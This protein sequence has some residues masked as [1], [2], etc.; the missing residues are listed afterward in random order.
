[1]STPASWSREARV[2]AAESG[3]PT[4]RRISRGRLFRKYLVLILTLVTIAL[5]VSGGISIYFTYQENKDALATLQHEK[6]LAAASRIEQYIGQI[7]QQ[8]AYAALPQLDAGDVELRRIEFLKLLRQAPEVTDI[9]QIDPGGHEQIA[10]SRLGMDNVNS[11]KDRSGEPAFQNAKRGKAWFGPVYFRKETEPYMTIA[12]RSGNDKGPVTVAEV[13]LKFIW[14]VVSRIKIGEK[15]KAYVVDGNGFLIADPDIG[16]VLR[17]TN[18]SNLAHV[19]AALSQGGP[20]EQAMVSKDLADIPVLTAVAP[21]ETLHWDVFVEQPVAEVYEKLN[22]SIVRTGLLLL[23]G[24]AISAVGAYG[25]ARGMVRPIRTLEEGAERI[26]SGNLDQRIEVHTGD[27]L[28]SLAD[29]FN[30]MTAQLRESYAGLE[31]KVEERTEELQSSLEQ[32][33]AI[34]EILRVISSSPTDVQPVLDAVAERAANLCGAPFARVVLI[35][36]DELRPAAD[37]AVESER[38]PQPP[39]KIPFKRSVLTGRA[40]LDLKT[41]HHADI[42]PLLETEYPDSRESLLALGARAVLVV[43]LMREGGAYGGIILFRREPELFSPA[44]VA[45]VETFARQA[46]IAIDNVRLFNETKESLDQQTAISEVLRVISSSP[47]DV[48]P[49]LNAVAERALKLC[50]AAQSTIVLVDGDAL[51]CAAAFGDTRTLEEGELMPLTR[52]SVAGRAVVDGVPFQIED[53]AQASEE[54]LPVGREL[55]RRV[56]HHT[57]LAVPLMR[58]DHAIGAIQLWRMETRAFTEKQVAL[59]KTFADQAAIA[60]ENARLFAEVQARTRELQESLEYQTATSEVLN[61]ISRSPSNIEPVLDA[62]AETAQRLCQSEHVFI[63]RLKD[64]LYH[65]AVAKNATPEQMAFLRANPFAADRG[66]V[67]GR[68]ALER[69][70]I[71]IADVLADPE[72]TKNVSGHRGFRTTLGVPLLREGAVIGVIV[73]TRSMVQPFAQKQIDLLTTFAD[74]AV[75]AIENVRLFNETKES[76]DQQTAI[77]EVLRVISTSPGDVKPMLNAVAE[78]ALSLCDAAESGI[79]F[80]EGNTLR[81]AAG[82]GSMPIPNEN[83]CWPLTRALVIGRAVVD[84]QTIHHADIVPLL[85]TEYPDARPNHEKYGFRAILTVPLMREDRAI[86]G[87][88]LWRREP[89]A[90]T[91][92]QIALVKTFADQAAIA[93]ENVRL[94]NATKEAL[95]QQTAVAE[96]LRVISSSPTDVLPVLDAIAERAARLCDASAASMYLIEGD[97]LHH[98]ASKGPSPDPV[99]HIDTLPIN[100]DSISGRAL[101]ERR[102]IEVSDMLAEGAEYPLSYDIAQQSGHRTVLVV[103]LYREG[104]PFGTVLLRRKDVRPFSERETA[105]LRTFGDQ[106][107]IA[108]ENVRLFNE[109]KEALEQ[110]RASG[111]VLAA[112]SSSIADATPV[113]DKILE[114]CERLFSGKMVGINLVGDDGLVRLGAYHGPGRKELEKIMDT[115]TG[116]GIAIRER[117]TVHFPDIERDAGASENTKRACKAIG[118]RSVVFAP[119]LWEGNGIGTIFVGRDFVG[120]FSE[121]DLAL[122]K[123][124]AD[125]AVIAI[126]NA[127]LFNET[128][129]ALE[130]QRASG[131][132]LSAI[133]SSIADT[134]PVF[135]KILASCE[136]LFAG[137]VIAINLLGEDGRVHRA[138]YHGPDEDKLNQIVSRLDESESGTWAAVVRRTVLHYPDVANDDDVPPGVRLGAGAVGVKAAILAPMLWENKGIGAVLVGRDYVGPFSEKEIALL[139][140]FADQAVI[141]IQNARLFNETKEALEQQRASG[142]VLAAISSSIADTTPVFDKILD[143]CERLFVGRLVQINLIG[144]D[145]LVHLAAYHGPFKGKIEPIFPF[146]LDEASATG[147]AILKRGVQHFPDVDGVAD[148]PPR[149]RQGWQAM[150]VK[151]AIVA[152]MLWEGRGIGSILVGRDYA[153]PFSDKEIALLK[154]FADQAVIAIQNARLFREIQDKSAQLEVANKHKSEFLANMSHELRTPLNAII[155]FSEVLIERLFGEVNEKQADYLNDIHSSGKHLLGLINDILDLSKVEAGRMELEPSMFD[156]AEAVANAMTLVRER[157]QKHGIALGQQVDPKLGEITADERKFK[158][159]LL[160]LLSNAVKFTPDGGR[161]DVLATREDSNAI[162]AVH[163]TGIGIAS[164][165]QAAVFEEFRQVGSDY[166]KKQEGTGLGLALTKKFVELHGGKIWLESEP[167][168]GSTFTFSIPLQR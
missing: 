76:L 80:A 15:G 88:A 34:S 42:L 98:L 10:V 147:V 128:N 65:V 63:M 153:G 155:G 67:T 163:D 146:P 1:M 122:V 31:R 75:I 44:Q 74:Q 145:G 4:P 9:A 40:A 142:E 45:L 134:K 77:S 82:F 140:T 149:A 102:T 43:P 101:L 131:E 84:R 95:E 54:E 124:F 23:V 64:G 61:V 55:Q 48:K 19:M 160:N 93:I 8:L 3:E 59:V 133:S 38:L 70:T 72:Y 115:G 13:N 123:T 144:E 79:F 35:D 94:F 39:S 90:F 130:Q 78:R 120:P 47:G 121:K 166:T 108:M 141:A 136:R 110:Q 126:Q 99:S 96:I 29:R 168:K 117:R 68:V 85:D 132:V 41:I 109:T 107:A 24:L 11:G 86:G 97:K 33:T 103:P 51:R 167:G 14:D 12:L 58:E 20:G 7:E 62:I 18:L 112:I 69:R 36:G 154:T 52:G 139:K 87:I 46:A 16:L 118:A 92:K 6:A 161:I 91:D 150:G 111:E 104:Q 114:S 37:Y 57:A 71:H 127:R 129:E 143:R 5:L 22:A 83:D 66:S 138:A 119:M 164:Q 106:A 100:R 32:Q 137:K 50:D 162:I 125:Q 105:L 157:A 25:L 148:V 81:F 28:E 156:I 135:D 116:T 165:D 21:I 53:L 151:S 152:P 2:A 26:G 17:K 60:I 49:M 30:R 113:F 73:L 158:Q 27:E 56:G 159:I 89:R